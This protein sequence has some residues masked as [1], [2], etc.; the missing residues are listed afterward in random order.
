MRLL[1][2]RQVFSILVLFSDMN[3]SNLQLLAEF[4]KLT[5]SDDYLTMQSEFLIF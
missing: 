4:I 5:L 3:A 1:K 2:F